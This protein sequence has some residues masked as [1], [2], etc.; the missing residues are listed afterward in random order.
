MKKLLFI[1]T[2]MSLSTAIYAQKDTIS[3]Y[4]KKTYMIPMRDGVKLFTVVLAP[5]QRTKP[6][7]FLIQRTPYGAEFPLRTPIQ[8][9]FVTTTCAIRTTLPLLTKCVSIHTSRKN[10]SAVVTM[11]KFDKCGVDFRPLEVV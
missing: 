5:T 8:V 1:V 4:T 6:V 9:G 7:P 10:S 2:L 11:G 3:T